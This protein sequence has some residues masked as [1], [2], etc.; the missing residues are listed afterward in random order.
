MFPI[1]NQSSCPIRVSLGS[2][3]CA[4]RGHMTT[5]W[6]GQGVDQKVD[7]ELLGLSQI[8]YFCTKRIVVVVECKVRS[9]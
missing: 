1:S 3:A 5:H 7:V 8:A 2:K 6:T 4:V 9:R